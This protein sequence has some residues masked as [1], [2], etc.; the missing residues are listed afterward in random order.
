[1]RP[2]DPILL[3]GKDNPTDSD[4][5]EARLNI[6]NSCDQLD[7]ERLCNACFCY[8]DDK[9]RNMQQFCPLRKW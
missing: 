5:R 1:M 3:T 4:I 9:T 8:I 6:C 7:K 2:T